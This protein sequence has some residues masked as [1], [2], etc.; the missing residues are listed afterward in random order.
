MLIADL[1]T[2]PKFKF[3]VLILILKSKRSSNI[4]WDHVRSYILRPVQEHLRYSLHHVPVT[5]CCKVFRCT[6]IAS[7]PIRLSARFHSLLSV[8]TMHL[9][10]WYMHAAIRFQLGMIRNTGLFPLDLL[11]E[12]IIFNIR[13]L[14]L[15]A[16]SYI[17]LF[18]SLV[19][20]LIYVLFRTATHID[21]DTVNLGSY[22]YITAC[23]AYCDS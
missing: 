6:L 18:L 3:P 21:A 20:I 23:A 12:L 15:F 17:Y 14:A 1:K 10:T 11:S 16:V 2:L 7:L 9:Y 5:I 8:L 22:Y 4:Q 19:L 13:H